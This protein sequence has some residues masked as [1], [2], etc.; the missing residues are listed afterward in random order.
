MIEINL[1]PDVKR[2]LLRAQALRNF[3]IFISIVASIAA[4]AVIIIVLGILG[5]QE[6]IKSNNKKTIENKFSE[7]TSI[8]DINESIILQ[9]QL[10]EIDNIRLS[11]P[12]TSRILNQLVVA[13]TSANPDIKLST[14]QYDPE[15]RVMSLEG[16][17]DEFPKVE[18]FE[19][20]IAETSIL[21]RPRDKQKNTVCTY[22]Q[23]LKNE[24]DCILEDLVEGKIVE[25]H[26]GALAD[27]E[28]GRKVVRFKTVFT[29]NR[30]V[31]AFSSKD[32]AMKIPQRTNV[33]DSK[34][35]IPDGIFT[36]KVVE[37][38]E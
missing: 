13:V 25:S 18:A 37:G 20:T 31:L 5:T 36:T 38:D 28:E 21:F 24:D 8:E 32:L 19:K 34:T 11:A 15:T 23:A 12:N 35:I 4:V 17:V 6:L 9:S 7:L 30:N 16:Q 2:E 22:E 3:V 33:T 1:I 27:N 29:L 14:I 26:E 10:N